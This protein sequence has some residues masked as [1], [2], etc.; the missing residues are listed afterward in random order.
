MMHIPSQ[1]PICNGKVEPGTT[2]FAVDLKSGLIVVRNVP[3][4][5]CTQC[6]E[7]WLEDSTAIQLEEIT[8]RAKA[9]NTQLE[10]VSMG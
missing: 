6:G 5:I 10:V 2:T 8:A 9:Q 1:C 4:L 3:A 7:E